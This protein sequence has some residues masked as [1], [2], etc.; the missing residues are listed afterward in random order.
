MTRGWLFSLLRPSGIVGA[1]ILIFAT[2]PFSSHLAARVKPLL[3][4]LAADEV[5]GTVEPNEPD[6]EIDK[7]ALGPPIGWVE[8]G[9]CA[10]TRRRG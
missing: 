3:D 5:G 2:L 8:G 4:K 7:D 9:H 1:A 6:E 10:T